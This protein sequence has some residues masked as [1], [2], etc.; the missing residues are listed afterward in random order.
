MNSYDVIVVGAGAAGLMAAIRASEKGAR[1]CVIEKN[2]KAGKKIYITGKGR[3]NLTNYCDTEEMFASFVSNP[4]FMYSSIY[5]FSNFSV[6]DWFE[7]NG[8]TTKVERGN[9]V[10]PASDKSSDVIRTLVK[11][12]QHNSVD[13]LF[14]SVVSDVVVNENLIQGVVLQ[15]GRK[16]LAPKVILCS[17]GC[18]YPSTG[19]NG[20][21]MRI[22]QKYGIDVTDCQPA[23]VPMTIKEQ[24]CFEMQGLSLK[25]VQ[26]SFYLGEKCIYK[27]FGEMMFTHFGVTGPVIL[28]ASSVI[29]KKIRSKVD[30]AIVSIDCKPALTKEKLDARLVRDFEKTPNASLKNILGGLVP[31]SMVPVLLK[32]IHH[33]GK[34]PANQVPKELREKIVSLLKDFRFTIQ[35]FRGWKEAI[36]TQG[37][38]SVSE[39]NP[40]TMESKKIKGLY[41]AG[42]VIDVDA[43]TG[44]FNLQI[45]WSTG[46]LAGDQ[47]VELK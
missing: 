23:L 14:E 36:I 40:S 4:K 41:F 2:E 7:T 19:S 29:G 13:F 47:A 3:C 30:D 24:D 33:D 38:V 16:I 42:E 25:N 39:I 31:K 5:S 46:F 9:R 26:V 20:D 43:L 37:G 11:V 34:I 35:G 12:C 15:S 28:S 17:G 8:L 44:G 1:V 27:E 21:G 45:A 32:R 22:A 10:F 18:S 6:V